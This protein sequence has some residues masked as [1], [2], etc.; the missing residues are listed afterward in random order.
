MSGN[1]G[2]SS[3]C[4]GRNCSYFGRHAQTA[5]LSF[6][7]VFTS[8]KTNVY[9]RLPENYVFQIVPDLTAVVYCFL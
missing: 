4:V 7:A 3:Q 2:M 9:I 1:P 6:M 5:T 8:F